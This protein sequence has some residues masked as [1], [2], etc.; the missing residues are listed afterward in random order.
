[1]YETLSGTKDVVSEEV[2]IFPVPL[3]KVQLLFASIVAP[4][5]EALERHDFLHDLLD[6]FG[7]ILIVFF[8]VNKVFGTDT[9]LLLDELTL[10]IKLLYVF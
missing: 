5:H 10:S 8:A 7:D 2:I 9:K 1:M 4:L 3:L 6:E